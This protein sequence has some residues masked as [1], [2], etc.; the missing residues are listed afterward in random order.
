MKTSKK[1]KPIPNYPAEIFRILLGRDDAMEDICDIIDQEILPKGAAL[2]KRSEDEGDEMKFFKHEIFLLIFI[3]EM[4][5]MG[6][7]ESYVREILLNTRIVKFARDLPALAKKKTLLFYGSQYPDEEDFLMSE[8]PINLIILAAKKEQ[9]IY[10]GV[11]YI[12]SY[13]INLTELA[14]Q[15]IPHL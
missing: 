15:L 2:K 9:E 4:L 6:I 14:A 7:G 13:V 1:I 5:K 11:D 8:G 12:A 3:N 10:L